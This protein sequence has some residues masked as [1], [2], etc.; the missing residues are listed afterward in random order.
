MTPWEEAT[1]GEHGP[2]RLCEAEP[3]LYETSISV[4]DL[5]Q[6]RGEAHRV[7]AA[8]VFVMCET[9]LKRIIHADESHLDDL[10]CNDHDG[11]H[12]PAKS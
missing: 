4:A 2:C 5:A 9:C 7:I 6:P 1:E 11:T 10:H 8:A 12:C 3:A